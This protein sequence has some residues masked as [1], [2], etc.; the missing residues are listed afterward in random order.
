VRRARPGLLFQ[1]SHTA[2]IVGFVS[3]AGL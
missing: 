1:V 3:L 2:H